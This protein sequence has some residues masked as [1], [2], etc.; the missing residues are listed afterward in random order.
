MCERDP[1]IYHAR[2]PKGFPIPG[3]SGQPTA[4]E[5]ALWLLGELA[6]ELSTALDLENLQR[7]LCRKLRWI[8][9]C[10]RCTLAVWCEP[11]DTEYLLF[12]ITSPSKAE[13]IPPQKILLTQGWPGK[14]LTEA[15]PYFIEDLTQL[16]PLVA[17]PT[18]AHWGIDLQAGSLMLLPLRTGERTIGSLN[19]S[20]KTPGTYS[21]AWRSLA[22]LLATQVGGQLGSILAHQRTTSALKALELSQTQLKNAQEAAVAANL[23]K[24][25]FLA[26]MS[27]EIRTPLNA[28]IGMTSLLLNKE[29]RPDQQGFVETIRYSSDALL[30]II[31][32]I[33]DFSKIESG[34]LE[35]EQQPFDL[36]TC[37][38]ESL[39]LVVSNAAEKGLKLTY[40]I[41]PPTPNTLVGD[42][43]RL[44]QILV[45]LLSNA[46]KF[47]EAGSVVVSVTAHKLVAP[48]PNP[49]PRYKICFAVK[50][51]GIGISH[52]QMEHLF[53]SF[54]Q[55]DSS[56]NRRYGGTGL[57]LAICKQLA[58]IMGGS[59]WVESLVGTGSTFHFT[60]VAPSSPIKLDT[61]KVES[62]QAIPRLAEHLP[63][64][65]LL[66]EDNRVN[67]QVALLILEQLGYQADA[68]GNGL[69]V[70]ASLH[71]QFYDVVLMDVQMPEMDGL[72]AT[73]HIY[74]E[75]PSGQRPRII[76]MTAYA[77]QSNWEQCLEAGM[78]DY[79]SKP[80]Q[81]AKLVQALSQCQQVKPLCPGAPLD[82][83]TLQS[84]RKMAGARATVVLAQIIDNYLTEA[85]QLLQAM[86][87]AVVKGD[88]AAL[89]QAAHKL[90][91]AS[92][93]L[94]ATTLSQL[95]K[96]LEALGCAGTTAEALAGVLQVESVYETVK[97]ALQME[98][99]K[100]RHEHKGCP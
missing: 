63:L 20:A 7:I 39:S 99:I 25:K 91:S 11:S 21:I 80:I 46:V 3:P 65:I 60:L 82:T 96:A 5:G 70:L 81:I 54:N 64:R 86:R 13:H 49:Y 87:G 59:I 95:C 69:E 66:A 38:D 30:T 93:N 77:F 33:L 19:F 48:L 1:L 26:T 41:A 17:L 37:V 18:N 51:T 50:D 62:I 2:A 98:I 40:S 27:H 57:G 35:L 22:T 73:R 74:Q 44:S 45:N 43:A 58:E 68:V 55:V 36:Q 79:I 14:V 61:S 31:N 10:D 28:V 42:A 23:A 12:E 15:K 72:T 90:R 24:S 89:Q 4:A 78:N 34:N 32:D 85:P 9:D 71:R 75:W 6:S 56:I 97:A 8:F 76:A 94:G 88:A 53:K 52:E 67:Q 47:T 83:K 92:A 29:L 100:L 16:S 84:L